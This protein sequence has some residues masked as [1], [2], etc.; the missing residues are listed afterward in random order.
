MKNSLG[1][2]L[3]VKRH[4]CGDLLIASRILHVQVFRSN[5]QKINVS[6]T[7]ARNVNKSASTSR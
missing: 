4:G 1:Q 5:H 7:T 3:G 6:I 2:L